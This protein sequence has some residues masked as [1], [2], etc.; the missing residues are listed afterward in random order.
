MRNEVI[1]PVAKMGCP[2]VLV[3]DVLGFCGEKKI[4]SV[5]I[6]F[7]RSDGETSAFSSTTSGLHRLARE[8]RDYRQCLPMCQLF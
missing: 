4:L 1:E 6:L 3:R 5:V 2:F 7:D 8:R